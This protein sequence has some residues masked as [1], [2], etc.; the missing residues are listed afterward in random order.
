[1]AGAKIRAQMG[2]YW[3]EV[4]ASDIKE[5]FRALSNYMEV[6]GES[7]CG[8]C[9][10]ANIRPNHRQ[11]GNYHYYELVCNDCRAKLELGQ[12]Q[13]GGTLFPKRKDANGNWDNENNGWFD[14]RERQSEGQGNS[15]GF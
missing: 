1:M 8:K 12:A 10:S 9:G 13:E 4:D 7:K 15:G 11:S 3:I 14:Y 2:K 5:A 6:L